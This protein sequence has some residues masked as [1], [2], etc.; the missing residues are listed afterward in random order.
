MTVTSAGQR[1][2][3]GTLITAEEA[4]AISERTVV[5]FGTFQKYI[6]VEDTSALKSAA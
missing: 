4:D 3:F 2:A 5:N 1:A 6:L